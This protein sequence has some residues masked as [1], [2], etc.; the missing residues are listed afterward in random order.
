M[1]TFIREALESLEP[2]RLG[3]SLAFT[4]I[5]GYAT[6][7]SYTW[8]HGFL[9]LVA[10]EALPVL[11]LSFIPCV[12]AVWLA[13]LLL[14]YPIVLLGSPQLWANQLHA[15]LAYS[16]DDDAVKAAVRY[17]ASLSFKKSYAQV[18][19]PAFSTIPRWVEFG[20]MV[21]PPVFL[22]L[23]AFAAWY[24]ISSEISINRLVLAGIVVPV[25]FLAFLSFGQLV[26]AKSVKDAI[27]PFVIIMLVVVLLPTV[28]FGQPKRYWFKFAPN[29][30]VKQA[31]EWAGLGGQLPVRLTVHDLADGT[32]VDG[33]L[34]FFDGVRA[35]LRPCGT[36]AGVVM[37]A[38]TVALTYFP[39]DFCD[40]N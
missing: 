28:S 24:A 34:I 27:S 3:Q 18:L 32:S 22:C 4:M 13:L 26:G 17:V 19:T 14:F 20:M 29:P 6:L 10:I 23:P 31:L 16:D 5:I 7:I 30:I 11:V 8:P 35:W 33:Y 2:V 36:D 12:I 21:L 37:Q 9:P 15:G 38:S 1:L 39:K 25:L 40:V